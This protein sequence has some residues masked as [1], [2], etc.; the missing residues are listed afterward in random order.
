MVR[1]VVCVYRKCIVGANTLLGANAQDDGAGYFR[2]FPTAAGC[3][4]CVC[5]SVCVLY[6][7]YCMYVYIYVQCTINCKVYLVFK[8]FFCDGWDCAGRRCGLMGR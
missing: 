6:T 2:Q 4:K 8:V 3:N 7:R 5:L 1:L